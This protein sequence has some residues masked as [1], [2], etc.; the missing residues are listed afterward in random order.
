MHKVLHNGLLNQLTLLG[1]G[2]SIVAAVLLLLVYVF[3]LKS[4]N[5]SWVALLSCTM[6]TV[7]LCGLQ[8][9]HSQFLFNMLIPFETWYYG[10]FI[11]I[12]PPS[13]Y[14]FSRSILFPDRKLKNFHLLHL[15]PVTFIVVHNQKTVIVLSFLLGM[16][17]CVWLSS[18]RGFRKRFREEFFFFS[19]FSAMAL[20]ILVVGI[21]SSVNTTELFYYVYANSISLAYV[22]VV[23]ALLA[24]PGLIDEI[25][26]VI[27]LGYVN[28]TLNHVNVDEEVTKL[29]EL[30]RVQKIYQNDELSLAQLAAAMNLSAHQLSE[31]I[32]SHFG[33]NFSRYIR[34]Q[35]VKEARQLLLKEKTVSILSISMQVG[36]KSQSNFYAAFK[37]EEGV[38]PGQYREQNNN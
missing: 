31:L 16:V 20:L 17:Y 27:A 15:L 13:F 22:L 36:F 28:S 26:E 4:L 9:T 19:L 8:F 23:F 30:M 32:N 37:E 5:R 12:A 33:V 29:D 2:Y 35:R 10:V 34:Q 18:I 7:V 14:F 6:F 25:N 1:I 38:S 11:F 21:L 24:K 3:Y